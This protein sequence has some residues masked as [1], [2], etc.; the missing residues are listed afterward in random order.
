MKYFRDGYV[1]HVVDKK[2]PAGVCKSMVRYQIDP[3][4]CKKCG[5]CAKNC[6]VGCI[7]GDKNTPYAID[8]EKCVKCGMCMEKCPF[9]SVLNNA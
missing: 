7:T 1:A 3:D 8:Q 5:I 2:C 6:P 9:K 4:T